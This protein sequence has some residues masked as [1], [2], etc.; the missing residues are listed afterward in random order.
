MNYISDSRNLLRV[1]DNIKRQKLLYQGKMAIVACLS[2]LPK[3]RHDPHS[4]TVDVA[5]FTVSSSI[6][7]FCRTQVLL[8]N[9]RVLSGRFVVG[10]QLNSCTLYFQGML[11]NII[12]CNM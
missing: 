5:L 4:F 12:H 9:V 6:S 3:T 1:R 7:L 8:C 2:K 11:Y 10:D